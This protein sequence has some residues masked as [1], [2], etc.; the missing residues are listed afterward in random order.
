M[1]APTAFSLKIRRAI[2]SDALAI[3][4]IY[5][6]AIIEGKSTFETELR[7]ESERRKW[8]EKHDE[9]HPIFVAVGGE[10]RESEETIVGWASISSYRPRSCHSGVG[11]ISVY[12]RQNSRGRGVGKRLM[13]ALI[14]EAKGLGYWKLLSRTFSFNTVSLELCKNCGFREVGVYVKHA[15]LNGKWIDTVIVERLIHGNLT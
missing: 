13:T 6:Q 7:T 12:V 10:G 11:K 3:C 2:I 14:H 8:I 15:K 9:R 5:N 4:E 1:S